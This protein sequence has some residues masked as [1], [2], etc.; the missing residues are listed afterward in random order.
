MERYEKNHLKIFFHS[1]VWEF[2]GGN[3]KLIHLFGSL[4]F[5]LGGGNGMERNEKNHFRIFFHSPVWEF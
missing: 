5:R 2:N 3:G 1:F 4:R